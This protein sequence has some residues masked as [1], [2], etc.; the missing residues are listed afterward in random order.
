MN[1]PS[2]MDMIQHMETFV[3]IADSGSIS[4]AARSMRLSV[5]MTSRHLSALEEHLGV[6]LVRRTT[7]Q[8]ALTEQGI[9]FL[10]RSRAL[11]TGVQEARDA[12]RAGGTAAGLLV[13]SLPVS[14]GLAQVGPMFP[15]LLEKYPLLK[16]DLRFEDRFVDLLTDGVDIAIRAGA[17]PPDSP[18][19]MA[20]KLGTFERV[21]CASTEFIAKHGVIRSID[22]LQKIPCVLQGPAPTMWSFETKDGP[23]VIELCGRLRVNNVFSIREAVIAGLGVAR[24]PRWIVDEDLK[25]KRLLRVLPEA[26]MPQIEIFAMYHSGAKGSGAI[27]ATLDYLQQE[28]PRRTQM[29]KA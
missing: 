28:L 4:K 29:T 1:H 11:V 23:Q 7:R 18:Y 12:V 14:F 20:R 10:R 8:L 6:Q 16:L 3:R 9:E 22:G 17:R 5:A 21:L 2:V 24:L 27:R 15:A 25:R 19:I 13:I 26:V